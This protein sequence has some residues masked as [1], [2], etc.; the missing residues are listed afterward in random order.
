M[1]ACQV[2]LSSTKSK[3][4]SN[5]LH[6]AVCWNSQATNK[7]EYTNEDELADDCGLSQALWMYDKDCQGID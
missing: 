2:A 1:V 4:R 3:K 6:P 5:R 7:E